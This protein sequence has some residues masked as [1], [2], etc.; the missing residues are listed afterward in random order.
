[1]IPFSGLPPIKIHTPVFACPICQWINA[2]FH[3]V[4]ILIYKAETLYVC[5]FICRLRS[6]KSSLNKLEAHYAWLIQANV[7]VFTQKSLKN[8]LL[9]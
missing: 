7:T 9:L 8:V 1:M 5:V 3:G 2:T 6:F 4:Y